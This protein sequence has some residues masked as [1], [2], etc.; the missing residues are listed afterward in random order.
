MRGSTAAAVL[1]AVLVAE[2][3]GAVA[4]DRSLGE[5]VRFFTAVGE[6]GG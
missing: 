6:R 2:V 1:L 3:R 5:G 4:A